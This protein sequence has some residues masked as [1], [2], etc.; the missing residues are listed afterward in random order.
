MC[1]RPPI[2]RRG[3]LILLPLATSLVPSSLK[4]LCPRLLLGSLGGPLLMEPPERPP[5]PPFRHSESVRKSRPLADPGK[6]H[7]PCPLLRLSCLPVSP[8]NLFCQ[9]LGMWSFFT[10]PLRLNRPSPT[11]LSACIDLFAPFIFHANAS[12]LT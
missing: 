9:C 8:A 7:S 2:T 5:L 12:S 1:Q 10:F 11:K 4:C 3:F 6:E